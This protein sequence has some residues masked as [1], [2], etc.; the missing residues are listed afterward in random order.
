MFVLKAGFGS[1][2]KLEQ[3]FTYLFNCGTWLALEV[4]HP[5]LD[6][7]VVSSSPT[8]GMEPPLKKNIWDA[9]WLRS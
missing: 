6:F 7:R 8:L 1:K 5:T 3:N 9:G 2:W 4:E